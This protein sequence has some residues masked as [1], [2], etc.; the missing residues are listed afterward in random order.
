MADLTGK[1]FRNYQI[2]RLL[3]NG[4]FADVYLAKHIHLESYVAMKILQTRL[5]GDGLEQFRNEGR[6]IA[7]LVHPNIIRVFDF[8][9][10]DGFPFLIMDYASRGN[11]RQL[12]PKGMVLSTTIILPYVK[13]IAAA[14]QYAHDHKLIHRDVKPENILLGP[15]NEAILSDFGLVLSAQS[16]GSQT[17][18]EMAGTLPYMAPEQLHGKPRPQ[19]DQYAMGIMVYEW[20]SGSRPFQGTAVEIAAQHLMAPPPPLGGKIAGISPEIQEVI[21][22]ALEKEPQKRFATIDAFALALENVC[23]PKPFIAQAGVSSELYRTT[24]DYPTS[25]T[26]YVHPSPKNDPRQTL[27]SSGTCTP[28]VSTYATPSSTYVH[29]APKN[30]LHDPRQT[31]DSSGTC[32]PSP[33][34][35]LNYSQPASVTRRPQ[36]SLHPSQRFSPANN[37]SSDQAVQPSTFQLPGASIYERNQ[38]TNS[39]SPMGP[40]K[41]VIVKVRRKKRLVVLF[42]LLPLLL[43]FVGSVVAYSQT[44]LLPVLGQGRG[45][46]LSYTPFVS[47]APG[48]TST[49]LGTVVLTPTAASAPPTPSQATVTLTPTSKYLNKPYVIKAITG[50]PD[51]SQ[52]QVA[53]RWITG[54]T[55]PQS[56]TVNATD[57]GTTP[58]TQATGTLNFSGTAYRGSCTIPAGTTYVNTGGIDITTDADATITTLIPSVTVPAHAVQTG[59]AGNIAAGTINENYIC[60]GVGATNEVSFTGGKDKQTYTAVQQSDI[61][62]ATQAL[63]SALTQQAQ[64]SLT[65]QVLANE[66]LVAFPHNVCKTDKT[67]DH[68]AG[69]KATT[70]TVTVAVTCTDEAYDWNGTES[71]AADW[72]KNDATSEP[73]PDY[74]LVDN[75]ITTQTMVESE[76]DGTV[77]VSVNEAGTWIYQFSSTR[78]GELAQLIAGLSKEDAQSRLLQQTGVAK[79]RDIVIA[80]G[81]TLP[82]DSSKI[83]FKV[84]SPG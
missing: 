6:N 43:I 76:G 2:I 37:T 20:L 13:Q 68:V 32:T 77:D 5:I 66:R 11:L 49:V 73:G 52:H 65:A 55:Q 71:V 9:V 83:H 40:T 79:V 26:T 18:K 22:T 33:A 4:G 59:S 60:L 15:H 53:A 63:V 36:K 84:T 82:S 81:N 48:S 8:D 1:I 54:K 61:D 21:F 23:Q 24:T 17:T 69:D 70:V 80:G 19:S 50:T 74:E 39:F 34:I 41:P 7:S 58:A 29:T 25:A 51:A 57:T 30:P 14:L 42:V 31:L 38:Q 27:D 64:D 28:S 56:K 35:S 12:Y 75:E 16:T 47:H 3:G 45:G 46:P 78:Q 62:D 67:A 72:L 44:G 10:E